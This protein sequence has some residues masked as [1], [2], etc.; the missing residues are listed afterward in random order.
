MDITLSN[1]SK[2]YGGAN[3]EL[4]V[5]DSLTAKFNAGESVAIVGKSG[6][7]KSTLLHLMGGLDRPSSGAVLYGDS[8]I[9]SLAERELSEKSTATAIFLIVFIIH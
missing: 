7:G 9:S 6:I 8:N 3:R 4:R 1:V 2:T 5:I